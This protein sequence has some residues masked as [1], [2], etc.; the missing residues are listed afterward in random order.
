ML[1]WEERTLSPAMAYRGGEKKKKGRKWTGDSPA[2]PWPGSC[3]AR[4]C[5][6]WLPGSA[7]LP[8]WEGEE[9]KEK[10]KKKEGK[11]G[12]G[13]EV[14]FLCPHVQDKKT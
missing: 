8:R 2:I 9:G 14:I 5:I 7:G 6:R 12:G 1:R 11:H 3:L 10:K 4:I 13:P